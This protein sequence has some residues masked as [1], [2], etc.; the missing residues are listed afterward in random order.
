[1]K[2]KRTLGLLSLLVGAVMLFG[3]GTMG[4]TKVITLKLDSQPV[5]MQAHIDVAAVDLAENATK[6][7]TV[8]VF[9]VG[10]FN[11]SDLDNLTASLRGTIAAIQEGSTFVAGK[12]LRAFVVLRRYLVV[13]SNKDA[14]ILVCI[15]WCLADENNSVVYHEQFYA[16]KHRSLVTVGATKNSANEAILRRIATV[17]SHLAST[18]TDKERIPST[19]PDTYINFDEAVK[20]LPDE[21][22]SHHFFSG[23]GYVAFWNPMGRA[24]WDWTK[25]PDNINWEDYLKKITPR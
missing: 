23:S 21:L 8:G 20:S 10:E 18:N 24:Q 19:T 7:Q 13:T 3:C 12:K 6:L 5:T 22:Q 9:Q 16:S 17:C 2:M 4:G 1:M 15:G 25:H 14:A 11:Q